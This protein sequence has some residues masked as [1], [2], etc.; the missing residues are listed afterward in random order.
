MS[1]LRNLI[2]N[3]SVVI[4]MHHTAATLAETLDSLP[5]QTHSAW[6]AIVLEN[7]S[8][9]DTPTIAARLVDLDPRI[10]TISQPQS[11]VS[12][13][14]IQDARL[15]RYG[16]LFGFPRP[17]RGS[18]FVILAHLPVAK[19]GKAAPRRYSRPMRTLS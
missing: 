5:A 2:V 16:W 19:L 13:A 6:E 18:L 3:V 12:A 17:D 14:L 1:K 15:M 11:G 10:L 7:G 9:D 8:S 4:A